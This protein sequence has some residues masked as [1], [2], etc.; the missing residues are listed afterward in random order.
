MCNEANGRRMAVCG[1]HCAVR[2]GGG[3]QRF[4]LSP[5]DLFLL[6]EEYW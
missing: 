4:A 3:A 2:G 6:L 1:A 5:N